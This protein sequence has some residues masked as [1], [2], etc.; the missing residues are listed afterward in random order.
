MNLSEPRPTRLDLHLHLG[1]VPVR[2][3]PLFWA[4][5]AILGIRYYA[6]PEAGSIGYSA[7]WMAAV[8]AF[9][10]LHEM[11]HVLVGRL[12]GMRGEVVLYGLGGLTLGVEG[13]PRRW[14]RGVVLLA[15]PLV[16]LLVLAAVWGLTGLPIAAAIRDPAWRAV[17]ANG[18]AIVVRINYYWAVL[19][20]LP[21][22]PLDGGRIACE[23]G[24]G[25]FGRWGRVA[26]LCLCILTVGVLV[27]GVVLSMSWRANFTLDPR[28]FL[29]MEERSIWLLF[30]FLLWLRSFRALWPEEQAPPI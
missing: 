18:L 1:G 8:L 23:V 16:G 10:L 19:N 15:G 17:V 4:A 29:V 5:S 3:N 28:Y 30:C 25:L 21:L 14:Q 13:L 9:V 2:I 6:D 26:A 12:F 27:V 22:W 11:G 24:E 20:L 7:F